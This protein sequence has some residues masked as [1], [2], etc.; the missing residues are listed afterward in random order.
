M[1]PSAWHE[2]PSLGMVAGHPAVIGGPAQD[3]L[4]GGPGQPAPPHGPH[5]QKLV[6]ATQSPP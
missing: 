4:H 6:P 3:Q 5:T 2:V 1:V